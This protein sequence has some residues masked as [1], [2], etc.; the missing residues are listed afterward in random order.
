MEKQARTPALTADGKSASG[1]M[2]F[3][4]LPPSSWATRL[5]VSAAA[6]ATMIAGAGRPGERHHVDAGMSSHDLTDVGTRTV[7]QIEG[8]RRSAGGLHELSE[9]K[10]AHGSDLARLEDDRA[11]GCKRRRDFADDLVQGPVPGRD[12]G[13]DADRLLDDQARSAQPAERVGLERL[14]GRLE[15]HSSRPDL[16]LAGEREGS[17][18]FLRDGLGE[19]L[20]AFVVILENAAQEREPLLASC[21]RKALE[22]RSGRRHG[23]VDV[24]LRA[25]GDPCERLLG[26]RVD[27]VE[28]RRDHGI[29][30]ASANEELRMM[31]HGMALSQP[32]PAA[33][34]ARRRTAR[35]LRRDDRSHLRDDIRPQSALAACWR[36]AWGVRDWV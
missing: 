11:A 31:A 32:R 23:A 21:L 20:R 13:C 1:R 19:L 8:A 33:C 2:M 9:Q 15:M 25:G 5:T 4:D 29:H 35:N 24:L 30:P 14:D 3:G 36:P 26:R 28:R 22:S 10:T 27:H 7:D 12:Q 34:I 16:R 6:L 17:A 18:H